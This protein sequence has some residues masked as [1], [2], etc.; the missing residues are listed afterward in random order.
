MSAGQL[1]IAS[2][3]DEAA[4]EENPTHK[5]GQIVQQGDKVFQYVKFDNG[6]GNVAAA[7]GKL[8]YWKTIGTT[9]TSDNTDAVSSVNGGSGFFRAVLTDAY[10]GW[11][12]VWGSM[13]SATIDVQGGKGDLVVDGSTTDGTCKRVAQGTA[14]TH[15]Q[16]GILR[17]TGTTSP[18]IYITIRRA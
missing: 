11:Q 17:E 18:A 12:Q 16:L 14:G 2:K 5:L 13:N 15:N 10:H 9:I 1:A 6:A 8:A 3:F 7:A 4:N